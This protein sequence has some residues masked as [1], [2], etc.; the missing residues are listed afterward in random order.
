MHLRFFLTMSF[1]KKILLLIFSSQLFISLAAYADSIDLSV[2]QDS[3]IGRH[4]QFFQETNNSLALDAAI[5]AYHQG[6]FKFSDTRF[7]N[8]GI[9]VKPV[10]LRF[11]INNPDDTSVLRRLSLRTSWLD[12]VNV[13]FM[14]DNQLVHQY[15][16]GDKFPYDKRQ[17]ASRFFEFDYEYPSGQTEVYIRIKSDDPMVLPIYLSDLKIVDENKT[18]ES[19]SYGMLYGILGALLLYNL[20]VFFTLKYKRYLYYTIYIASFIATN[21]SYTGHG[22]RWWWPDAIQWQQWSNPV[23][24]VMFS[25]AGILF[26]TS[27]L[28]TRTFFPK[29]NKIILATCLVVANVELLF[30][31][32]NYQVAAL[33]LAFLFV[34]VFTATMLYLG[35]ATLNKGFVSAKYFLMA[36]V[37]HVTLS[38]VTAM[39]VW[40]LIPYS[41]LGYRALEFGIISDAIILSIALVIQLRIINEEKTQAQQLAMTDHLTGLNN[42]RAF[43]E[44]VRPIWSSG[45]RKEREMCV[46]MIDI[47]KFKNINDSYGHS[48]GDEVLKKLS[49]VL[50]LNVREGDIFARWGGEEFIVFLPETTLAEAS[51]VAERFRV[52]TSLIEFEYLG[53][54]VPLTISVGVAQNIAG[55]IEIDELIMESDKCLYVAKESGRN[56]VSAQR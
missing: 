6:W 45:L 44:Q 31:I 48:F 9:G 55:D 36:S 20:L 43:Y 56:Q 18:L 8:F 12:N 5:T 34:F 28:Q 4:I 54:S 39:T 35:I 26:A 42:R 3:A 32:F 1:M 30:V 51:E 11:S 38:S 37:T 52:L 41:V 16:V 7:L 50:L 33:Y 13:Y 29:F 19:Y 25:V 47:D 46:I 21:M 27:F 15:T 49:S 40:G 2:S 14:R 10:W 24:M 22:F 17:I 23:F 53:K